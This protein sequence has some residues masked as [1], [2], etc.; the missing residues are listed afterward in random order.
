M[1]VSQLGNRSD[2]SLERQTGSWITLGPL[3]V[4]HLP[5]FATDE[6]SLKPHVKE[7]IMSMCLVC[8][9]MLRRV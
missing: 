1:H 3:H 4:Q 2:E 8:A 7:S 6:V 5:L 9:G